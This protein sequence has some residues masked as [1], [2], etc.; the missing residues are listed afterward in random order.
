MSVNLLFGGW[1]PPCATPPS[2]SPL[3]RV[4][5]DEY[6]TASHDHHEKI[7]SWVSFSFLYGY[8]AS[9]GGPS[10]EFCYDINRKRAGFYQTRVNLTE[11]ESLCELSEWTKGAKCFF[12]LVPPT[13]S[14]H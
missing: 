13:P 4:R 11:I 12:A 14:R 3:S 9:L 2:S 8:G 6:H 5:A 7:N 1:P 10:A